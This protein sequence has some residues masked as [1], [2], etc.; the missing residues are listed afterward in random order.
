M[1]LDRTLID[2]EGVPTREEIKAYHEKNDITVEW[3]LKEYNRTEEPSSV[4]RF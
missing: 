4:V 2:K 1:K 3:L